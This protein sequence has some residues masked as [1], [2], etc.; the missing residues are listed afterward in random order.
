MHK[1]AAATALAIA[2]I[3]MITPAVSASVTTVNAATPYCHWG[4]RSKVVRAG[5]PCLIFIP[6]PTHNLEITKPPHEGTAVLRANGRSI[7]YSPKPGFT[8][9]DFVG[10]RFT[11]DGSCE[12]C[13]VT[14]GW[15]IFV[16]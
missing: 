5:T 16:E 1:Y 4:V 8:G 14:E 15:V 2:L 6:R 13:Y 11:P 9:R 12:L 3:T 7:Y 10:V